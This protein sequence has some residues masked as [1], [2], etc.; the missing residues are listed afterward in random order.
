M[1]YF[2]VPGAIIIFTSVLARIFI[3]RKLALYK[4]V[5]VLITTVGI[6]VVGLADIL[7]NPLDRNSNSNIPDALYN[8]SY[9]LSEFRYKSSMF[10]LGKFET[11]MAVAHMNK[12]KKKSQKMYKVMML[13]Q[14][15]IC[16]FFRWI[17]SSLVCNV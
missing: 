15:L 7:P 5:A 6:V 11:V 10:S 8:S 2:F 3:G 14:F 1:F 9:A 4:W 16:R 13:L 17:S 12:M